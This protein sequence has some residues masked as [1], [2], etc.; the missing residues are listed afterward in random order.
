MKWENPNKLPTKKKR[1]PRK[2]WLRTINNGQL[3][4]TLVWNMEPG[5]GSISVDGQGPVPMNG[6]RQVLIYWCR[7]TS[8]DDSTSHHHRRGPCWLLPLEHEACLILPAH[9]PMRLLCSE[10][11][12][13]MGRMGWTE[14]GP[15]VK[16]LPSVL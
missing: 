14:G 4:E 12:I 3:K 15:C 8:V 7:H 6:L 10:L 16:T 11:L 9:Y 2:I 1:S 13:W 5:G